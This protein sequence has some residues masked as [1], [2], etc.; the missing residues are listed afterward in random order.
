MAPAVWH[1]S[2]HSL[3]S[4]Q[5]RRH[6]RFHSPA[7]IAAWCSGRTPEERRHCRKS[8]ETLRDPMGPLA[9]LGTAG[10]NLKIAPPS[11]A[12]SVARIVCHG[13]RRMPSQEIVPRKMVSTEPSDSLMRCTAGLNFLTRPPG[14]N[15]P[16][17]CRPPSMQN[18]GA[19]GSHRMA[20]RRTCPPRSQHCV[21]HIGLEAFGEEDLLR[22][23]LELVS[24]N[25]LSSEVPILQWSPDPEPDEGGP[26]QPTLDKRPK[27]QPVKPVEFTRLGRDRRRHQN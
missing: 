10:A 14:K 13:V 21:S 19:S 16:R 27:I 5:S 4:P 8:A 24:D 18:I 23:L 11:E 20:R 17:S 2:W 3:R 7:R 15:V 6:C 1:P 26:F 25:H 9:V 12:S 22:R